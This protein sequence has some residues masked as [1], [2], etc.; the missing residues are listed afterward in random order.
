MI[1]HP[2]SFN[3]K[4]CPICNC[5]LNVHYV[6]GHTVLYQCSTLVSD[7]PS[8]VSSDE[9]LN[10]LFMVPHYIIQVVD[11]KIEQRSVIPPYTLITAVS[12]GRTFIYHN[13]KK[14]EGTG[15][16]MDVPTILPTDNP[17]KLAQRI[18]NLIIFS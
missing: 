6:D 10:K 5:T 11:G 16:I 3:I 17:E 13:E 8:S 7:M 1:P 9:A 15:F 4:T 12:S 14:G 18:K 2:K